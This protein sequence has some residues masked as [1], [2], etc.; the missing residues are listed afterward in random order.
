MTAGW[1]RAHHWFTREAVPALGLTPPQIAVY[2]V[3]RDRADEDGVTFPGQD[4]IA[5]ESGQSPR[6][7]RLA[8]K[9]LIEVGLVQVLSR[10]TRQGNRYRVGA[11]PLLPIPARDAAMH[12]GAEEIEASRASDSG[13]TC[14]PIEAPGAYEVD[15]G[16]KNQEVDP[17]RNSASTRWRLTDAQR[18]NVLDA[19]R[20]VDARCDS[21]DVNGFGEVELAY[22]DALS[23]EERRERIRAW[24]GLRSR[25][26][27]EAGDDLV[28]DDRLHD[29]LF[30]HGYVWDAAR[31]AGMPTWPTRLPGTPEAWTITREESA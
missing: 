6:A 7:V 25:A 13:T 27:T 3:L 10:G 17:S 23:A 8:L 22:L 15:P 21:I 2:T 19:L 29:L 9:R 5:R 12:E 1:V 20:A 31:D 24:S 11:R 14:L 26:L 18:R 28:E 16:K 4:L 30:A